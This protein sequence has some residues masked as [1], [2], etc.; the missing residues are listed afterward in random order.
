VVA[1][2]DTTDGRRFLRN[3]RDALVNVK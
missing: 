3:L 2:S 1:C